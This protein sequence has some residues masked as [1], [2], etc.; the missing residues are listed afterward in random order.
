MAEAGQPEASK[1][2]KTLMDDSGSAGFPWLGWWVLG[3]TA[4]LLAQA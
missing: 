3:E 4:R 2:W 1:R